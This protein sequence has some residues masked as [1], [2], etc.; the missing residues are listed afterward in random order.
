MTE[1]VFLSLD[2]TRHFADRPC[3]V[4]GGASGIGLAI[5]E[6]LLTSGARVAVWDLNAERL[7]NLTR[8]YGDRVMTTTL[9]VSEPESV[10]RA[11]A[12]VISGWG[13]IA[14]LVNNAGIIGRLMM[15]T[16]FD[17]DEFRRILSINLA[18]A[19]Q[20]TAAF[21]R[22]D[23]SYTDRSVVNLASIAARTG[24]MVGNMGYA[25]S[26]AGVAT[27]TLSMAKELAPAIRV[28]ALAPGII[29]TDMQMDSIGDRA[30]IEALADI[31]PLKRLGLAEEVAEA[32]IWLLSPAA[33]YITGSLID[34]A[35]GR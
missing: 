2:Y 29:D 18:G 26:K 35:G 28:N 34:V 21:V 22:R 16:D 25:A 19:A 20:V 17:P 3:L 6:R 9:D 14:H 4:T 33:S 1:K 24:G 11:M 23:S 5:T 31:I 30:S 32:A 15:L 8:R 13:G 10:E 27:M 12:E 7:E